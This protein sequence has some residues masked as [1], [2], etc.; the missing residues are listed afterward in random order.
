MFHTCLQSTL[1]FLDAFNSNNF[2]IFSF[3]NKPIK[4][5][6]WIIKNSNNFYEKIK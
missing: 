4:A 6:D 5:Y 3:N 2:M 1:K